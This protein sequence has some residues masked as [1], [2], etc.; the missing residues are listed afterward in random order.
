MADPFRGPRAKLARAGDHMAELAATFDGYDGAVLNPEPSSPSETSLRVRVLFPPPAKIPAVLGDAIHNL[1]AALDI[2]AVTVVGLNHQSV[3]GVYFPF[4]KRPDDL[5]AMI[6]RG[7]FHRA[8]PEAQQLVRDLKPYAAGNAA[9]R[10]IHDL[11]ILDKHNHLIPLFTLGAVENVMLPQNT[12]L[13]GL[14]VEL[15]DGA[16]VIRMSNLLA[17][18]IAS[19][20][21]MKLSAMFPHETPFALQEVLPTLTGLAELVSGVIDA[22]EALYKR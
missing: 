16:G 21:P 5:D 17:G 4:C 1:R 20:I 18:Q 6:K 9:L 22:F 15:Q 12:L 10:G 13:S 3:R 11:D 2:L 8:S 14:K 7:N 19:P